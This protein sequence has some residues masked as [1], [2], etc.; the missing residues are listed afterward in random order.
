MNILKR[1]SASVAALCIA[2]SAFAANVPLVS[3]PWDPTNA[4]GG[5]NGLVQSLNANVDGLL[6]STIATATTSGTTI[7]TLATYTINGGV[8][9][10]AGQGLHVHVWGVNSADAN[11]KTL[12]LSFGTATTAL[13]VTGSGN[14][15]VADFYILKTGASTQTIEGHG[16]T[17][18]TPVAVVASTAT[19]T[20]TAAITV[21][22][23]GTAATSG[24]MT[25][26][27]GYIEQVK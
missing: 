8:L 21:L 17:A 10:N 9:A 15:W 27:G 11:V 24:T 19:Q 16:L 26:S 2:T 22:V 23:S 7:S 6:G 5:I 4:L 12:T 20:D 14:T 1:L 25:L 18:T 13:V 3:G